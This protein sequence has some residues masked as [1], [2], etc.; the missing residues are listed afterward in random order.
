MCFINFNKED[1]KMKKLGIFLMVLTVCVLQGS[2]SAQ[3]L[4]RYSF[5]GDLTDSVGG[6][7]GTLGGGAVLTATALDNTANGS[8]LATP[9]WVD[10]PI[11]ST[12]AG[13]TNISFEWWI[14]RTE[15]IL[16]RRLFNIGDSHLSAFQ[17]VPWK[18][19]TEEVGEV[20]VRNPD[21]PAPGIIRSGHSQPGLNAVTHVVMN[22]SLD[23][24]TNF[25]TMAYIV[26]GVEVGSAMAPGANHP[27][28]FY[29]TGVAMI[30]AAWNAATT[31]ASALPGF[32]GFIDEFR[33]YGSNLTTAD[34]WANHQAGP[35]GAAVPEP[36]TMALFAVGSLLALRRRRKV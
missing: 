10:V 18:W 1:I 11:Q 29:A 33:I 22:Y 4:H 12:V 21:Q 28:S 15:D 32:V 8:T 36:M 16:F 3:I 7:T 6:A 24:G 19:A 23:P 31:P 5:N 2:A 35:D 27:A 14:T 25:A 9:S 34:A 17:A 20:W 13:L 26:D 30:G